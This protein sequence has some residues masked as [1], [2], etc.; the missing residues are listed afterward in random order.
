L[1]EKTR[2]YSWKVSPAVPAYNSYIVRVIGYSGHNGG[3]MGSSAK[4]SIANT[5]LREIA[6]A[7][8]Y[9]PIPPPG[10]EDDYKSRLP[11][12]SSATTVHPWT[13]WFIA[14][15]ILVVSGQM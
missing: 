15:W 1:P 12:T 4:I 2:S 14:L 3:V 6:P 7:D 10:S 9:A 11:G 5:I 8:E 13:M